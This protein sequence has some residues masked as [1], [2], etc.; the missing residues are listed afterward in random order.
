MIKKYIEFL[1]KKFEKLI[2]DWDFIIQGHFSALPL[3]LWLFSH[4]KKL[5][6]GDNTW[7]LQREVSCLESSSS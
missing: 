7:T 3:Q 5:I 4:C 1:Q 6:V 2:L